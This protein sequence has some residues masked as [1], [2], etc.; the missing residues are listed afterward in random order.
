MDLGSALI[1]SE[2][3]EIMLRI[4]P[5]PETGMRAIWDTVQ[6]RFFEDA[7]GDQSWDDFNDID[8]AYMSDSDAMKFIERVSRLWMAK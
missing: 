3:G 2:Y 5:I 4:V 1:S 7:N 8:C 6:D